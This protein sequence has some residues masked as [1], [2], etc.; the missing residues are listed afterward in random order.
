M[1]PDPDIRPISRRALRIAGVVAVT[2]AIII[3]A[4]GIATRA[5]NSKVVRQL[6][7][8]Q[9][10][11]V[12]SVAGPQRGN[13]SYALELPG[14]LQAYTQ[15]PIYARVSG[16]LKYWKVDIGGSVRAGQLL[17]EIEAPDLDQQLAQAK[18]DL[19]T[20]QAN[21]TLATTTAARW[22]V[23][24]KT[25]SVSRQDVDMRN[26]DLAAKEA[27]LKSTQANVDRL[28]VMEGFKRIVAP[29]SGIVTARATDVGALINAGSGQGLELFVLAD[30]HKLRLYVNIPQTYVAR[31][32][33]GTHAQITV[34]ER[35]DRTFTANV[36]AS[37]QAV[38]P[39]SGS[40]LV[41][42]A[43]NN[44]AG[45]LYPG[46]YATVHFDLPLA[47][48]NLSVPVSSLIFDHDGMRVAIV[49]SENRVT[50]RPVTIARD[51]GDVVEISS[52]L[53]AGDRIVDSPPDGLS[54]GDLVR[55]APGSTSGQMLAVAEAPVPAATQRDATRAQ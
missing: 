33:P 25:N 17:A 38:D 10:L 22:Q 49:E 50:F 47:S 18:A 13:G 29:F 34:P 37:A 46:A 6:T 19:M 54:N 9:A 44:D 24:I 21:A 42:L 55:I 52:G 26:G 14:R 20:A 36:E 41:Q 27:I 12:V 15:A 8:E 53:S 43:V 39:A 45:E 51:M 28:Q 16:Y 3:V 4:G 2:V 32:T 48:A 30:T 5:S 40:T 11:P 23:L 31:V 1:S 35:P 7:A